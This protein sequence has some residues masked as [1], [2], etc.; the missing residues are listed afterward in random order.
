MSTALNIIANHELSRSVIPMIPS[1][2]IRHCV[3]IERGYEALRWEPKPLKLELSEYDYDYS[4]NP[5]LHK[6]F[7]SILPL[8]HII[9]F[10][11]NL[12]L[13]DIEKYHLFKRLFSANVTM[14]D[15]CIWK[16]WVEQQIR[17]LHHFS[18]ESYFFLLE[19]SKQVILMNHQPSQASLENLTSEDHLMFNQFFHED[20]YE[21]KLWKVSPKGS[22]VIQDFI[23][24]NSDEKFIRMLNIFNA[25]DQQFYECFKNL[26]KNDASPENIQYYEHIVCSF[27][28]LMVHDR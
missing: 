21:G 28:Y 10:L 15:C 19:D 7:L 13:L 3:R 27:S 8:Q 26:L 14:L 11:D 6:Y 12:F 18:V 23:N 5:S 22:T 20:W 25:L 9:R 2:V 4:D 16:R 17:Y 1:C 24:D